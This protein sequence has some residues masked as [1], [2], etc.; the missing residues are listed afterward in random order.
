MKKLFF[1]IA[2]VLFASLITQAQQKN[3]KKLFNNFKTTQGFSVK[4]VDPEIDI[5]IEHMNTFAHFINDANHVYILQFEY[6]E[7]EKS[8]YQDFIF[9]LNKL[10]KKLEFESVMEV[11]DDDDNVK[12]LLRK[13]KD[14]K[15]SDFILIND[16]S[17]EG[18]VVWATVM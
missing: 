1:T 5:N 13:N 3:M 6:D 14:Q 2:I 9:K 11:S 15:V 12:I 8:D 10:I 18:T 4:I 16:E 7:G 17:D